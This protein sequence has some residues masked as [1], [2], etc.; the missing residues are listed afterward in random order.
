MRMMTVNGKE[1]DHV[2][3][4]TVAGLLKRLNFIF[5]LV[6]VKIDGTV[7]PR[8]SFGSEIAPDGSTIEVIHL[9]SGG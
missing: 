9:T 1:T 3:D 6:I 5:P 7:V 8:G 2:A 4:E